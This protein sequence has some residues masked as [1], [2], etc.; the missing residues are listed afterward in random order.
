MGIVLLILEDGVEKGREE[1][2]GNGMEARA[3]GIMGGATVRK[4]DA[5]GNRNIVPAFACY[6]GER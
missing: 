1:S 3:R 4:D 5:I 6:I 2:C